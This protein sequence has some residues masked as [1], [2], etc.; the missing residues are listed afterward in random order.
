MARPRVLVITPDFPPARGGIQVLSHR[1]VS[2]LRQCEPLVVALGTPDA[3]EFD[4]GQPFRIHRSPQPA[5]RALAIS[6]LNADAVKVAAR[7]RPDVV[8]STHIIAGPAAAFIR[9]WLG[10]PFVQYLHAKEIGARPRLAR[11][12]VTRA[13][14]VIAVSRYTFDLARGVGAPKGRLRRINPGVDLPAVPPAA[15]ERGAPP[16]VLTVARLE[17]R[18]KGHDVMMRAMPLVR[19]KLRDAQWIVIGDGPLRSILESQSVGVGLNGAVRFLGSVDDDVRD[20]WLRKAHVFAMVSR[21]PAGGFAGEGFGIVYLEANAHGLP[22]V[23]GGVG[24]ATDAVVDQ[25]TGLLVD[26][27]DHVAVA[28]ALISL[29][30]DPGRAR[31]LG[32]NGAAR[33]QNFAWPRV[34]ERVEEVLLEVL[35]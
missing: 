27:T 33:A 13:E 18:Y 1:V 30:T 12:A 22:V 4:A 9:R 16:T 20:E 28:Q 23:A 10:V 31:A 7:W 2:G 29:L 14:R 5:V 19:A 6:A 15:G 26:P 17:D 25:Q 35:R 3:A 21:L 32:E 34:A 11:F 24:G 8:L